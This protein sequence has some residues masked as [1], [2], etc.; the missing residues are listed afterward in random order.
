LTAFLA[1]GV[2]L[3][4][5]INGISYFI[6]PDW[7]KIWEV[8]VWYSA[9]SQILFSLSLGW[10][11][12]FALC[13]YNNFKNN[14]LRD[15]ILIGICNSATSIFAGFVV[16]TILGFLANKTGVPIEKV[17]NDGITLGFVS[18]PSAMAH[19]DMPPLWSFLFFFMLINLAVS[20]GC[21][22]IQTVAAFVMDEWPSL[23][24]RRMS[25]FTFI[26]ASLFILGLPMCCQGGILLFTLFDERLSSS[27]IFIVWIEIVVVTWF[28]GIN[29]FIDNIQEMGMKFGLSRPTGVIRIVLIILLA[30]VAPGMLIVVAVIGWRNR[31]PI[32]YGGESFPLLVES[33]GWL[34]EL[35]PLTILP[36]M[37]IWTIGKLGFSHG[38]SITNIWEILVNPSKSWYEVNRN[39]ED[40]TTLEDK[41]NNFGA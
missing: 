24:N 34:L 5:A 3:P 11:S 16:F 21:S 25:V 18:Y 19:M 33:F 29:Q 40:E 27:L 15:S 14:T 22:S 9:A 37:A 30:V 20:T 12:Q 10:G 17:V 1:Y 31:E 32:S 35:G 28:Y 23:R 6:K 2:T 13:S 7:N 36:M 8:N 26:A 39:G 41:E 4:G 38:F